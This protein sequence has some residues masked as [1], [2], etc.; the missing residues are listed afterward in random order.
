MPIPTPTPVA[1]RSAI[2]RYVRF[3]G[4]PQLNLL[5]WAAVLGGRFSPADLASLSGTAIGDLVPMLNTAIDAGVLIDDRG[6]LAFRHD[7][8]RS[9][10]YDDMGTAMRQSLHVEAARALAADGAT[11][12]Q[13]A[14]HILRGSVSTDQAAI[15]TLLA[16][17]GHDHPPR[18]GGGAA[19]R[20]VGSACRPT[21][22]GRSTSPPRSSH[23]R[24]DRTRGRRRGHGRAATTNTDT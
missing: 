18:C 2:I 10:L 14:H 22:A 20:S 19:H 1:F 7:L 13:I 5:R 15:E 3:L 4:E 16:A 6:R 8:L 21:T 24:P 23:S 17:A 11:P 9:A 12:L